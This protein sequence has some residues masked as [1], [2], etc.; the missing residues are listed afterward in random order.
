MRYTRD[1]LQI[2]GG[3][4]HYYRRVPK[5]V[6]HLDPRRFVRKSLK[7]DSE[8]VARR[9]AEIVN[10]ATERYWAEL[11]RHTDGSALDRY[12]AAV[13]LAQSLGFPYFPAKDL[14]VGDL[15]ALLARVEA[16][17]R[18]GSPPEAVVDGL[19]GGIEKPPLTLAGALAEFWDLAADEVHNKTERQV[20]KWRNPRKKAVR[21]LISLIGDRPIEAVARDDALMFRR[22]W[23][24]RIAD[25]ELT[26]NA[27]NK[28][29]GALAKLFRV[30][31][32][33][34]HLGLD[35][36]FAGLRLSEKGDRP[37]RQPFEPAFVAGTILN[38]ARLDGLNIEGQML[39]FAMADTGCG[40]TELTSLD[41]ENGDIALDAAIPHIRIRPNRWSGLKV[42]YRER[43]MPLVG[44]AAFA[45][46]TCPE[47]FPRYRGRPDS[48]S[49]VVN[50]FLRE[51]NLLPSPAHSAYSL[52]H[53]FEDRMT[54]IEVPEKIA[55]ALMGHKFFRPRYGRG[56]SLEQKHDWLSKI[57]FTITAAK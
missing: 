23:I 18:R 38:R 48:A 13:Q 33:G 5:D 47:G 37:D 19:L 41:P 36:P 22:W 50:K 10:E 20:R 42:Q 26:A 14:A 21:N 3:V 7:T 16:V 30:V 54:A 25:E 1:H 55:A 45:F 8:T 51:N 32:D 2:R 46:K 27:A 29:I 44:A 49:S 34:L 53:T 39:L 4:W 24:E 17:E 11:L 31:S 40:F 35:N 57:A 28:D 56:P 9:R 12:N 15:D 6:A 52:R 43:D